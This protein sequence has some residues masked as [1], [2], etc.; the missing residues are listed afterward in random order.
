MT[1]SF[2]HRAWLGTL[3]LFFAGAIT[4]QINADTQPQA[5]TFQTPSST[6]LDPKV[7]ARADSLLKQMTEQEKISLLSGNAEMSTQSIDRLKIPSLRFSDGPVGV[8]CWGKSTAYPADV[9]LAATWDRDVAK[10]MGTAI[11]RDARARGV[12]VVL[13]PG[14]NIYREAQNGRN[15]EY[16][17]EDPFLASAM[18]T[19][20]IQGVQSQGVSA[21]IKHFVANEQE[22]NRGSV[23]T[24]VSKRALEEIYFPPFKAAI[25]DGNV[26]TVMAAYNKINGEWCTADK[27]LLTDVLRNEWNFQGTLMSDWGA[28]HDTLKD[29]NAGTDLEMD[30][31]PHKFYNQEAIAPLLASGAVSQAT[32]DEH[33]RRLLRTMVSMGFMDRD[34]TD[35]S[36][37]KNDPQNADTAQKVAAEGIVLLKNENHLLPLDRTKVHHLAVLGPNAKRAVIGGGGSSGVDPFSQVSVLQALEAVAGDQ[38]RIDFIPGPSDVATTP[39]VLTPETAPGQG[40]SAEYFT[41]PNL[42]G[43][44]IA[45][46]VD[47]DVQFDWA[48]NSP[49]PKIPGASSFSVRWS[50]TI[51]PLQTGGYILATSSDDGSRVF[52]DGTKVIDLWSDHALETKVALVHLEK[53]HVYHVKVE[54]YNSLG[55][56][57][58]HFGWGPFFQPGGEKRIADAD[59]VIY[60]GGLDPGSEHEG[61]DRSW[62]IPSAQEAELNAI[63]VLNPRLIVSINAGGNLGLGGTL[64][65]IPALLWS[66]YPGQNGNTALAQILF[67][68]LNPS[69]RL[70]DSFEKRFEDSPAFGN[71]PGIL[72]NGGTVHLEEGIY[73]G[74]RWYDK[75]TIAPE[76]PFGFGLSY[77]TFNLKNIKVTTDGQGNDRHFTVSVD[78]TNTGSVKG[79]QIV[80]LYVRP[81]DQTADRPVQELK[82][83]A[84]V[85]L[86]VGTTQTVTLPLEGKDFSTYDSVTNKWVTPPGGY[87]IAVGTS[88]RDIA[89]TASIQW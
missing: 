1:Y 87:E 70:P 46:Q 26:W 38:T 58:M 10:A 32:I 15:F 3:T 36:I 5:N 17:G 27:Y 42:E 8:R 21:C 67:G 48:Q 47:H 88:S 63:A 53:D 72:T 16:F 44:P 74:Y 75:K 89:Q 11:G 24:I 77:T 7:E 54:Y 51:R 60:A 6:V 29:L 80:Q 22:T 35:S 64:Q 78:V 14:T 57:G 31:T 4:S 71:F 68:D 13:G 56:A 82:G 84:R 76:F 40:M 61:D 33:V 55:K 45:K 79:A 25:Q 69:G 49:V 23:D 59:A 65:K 2:L 85:E 62:A 50:G 73:V 43:T 41:N 86:N 83:F 34:Q 81:K 20:Y 30:S 19:N 28:T 39:C 12:H 18:V 37:P 9:M 52:L 66:W